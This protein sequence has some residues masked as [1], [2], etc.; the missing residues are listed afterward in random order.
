MRRLALLFVLGCALVLAQPNV[1]L[2]G[3][4][5]SASFVPQGLP[6]GAI[7]QGSLFTIFGSGLGPARGVQV[8]SFPLTPDGFHG[9]SVAVTV[10]GITVNAPVLYTSASQI[11]AM[12]PSS[13]PAG[14]GSVTVTY[15]S[16]TSAPEPVEVIKSSFGIFAVNQAG[17]GLAVATHANYERTSFDHAATAGEPIILWGTGLGPVIGAENVGPLP[18]HMPDVPAQVFVGGRKAPIA[19]EGRSGCCS[20]VDQIIFQVPSGIAGCAVP[21]SVQIG[22][23]ISNF[24]TMA[25]AS[26]GEACSDTSQFLSGLYS[27]L[28]SKGSVATGMIDLIRSTYTQ[29][30]SGGGTSEPVT[31]D[32]F[33]GIF[34]RLT[35]DNFEELI[36]TMP[37]EAV[38]A[39]TVG[40]ES[41]FNGPGSQYVPSVTATYLD[42]GAGLTLQGPG[43]A[44]GIGSQSLGQYSAELGHSSGTLYFNPGVYTVY[45]S[46]GADVGAFQA[47]V[48][49]TSSF[50]WS[51]RASINTINRSEGL[52]LSWSG[53]DPNGWVMIEGHSAMG[54]SSY[55]DIIWGTFTCRTAGASGSFT[56][57]PQV[58]LAVP[59]S[60]LPSVNGDLGALSGL[61]IVSFSADQLFS[62]PGLDVAYLSSSQGVGQ[63]VT[64]K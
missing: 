36:S 3:I 10:D 8:S 9:T 22:D 38:G 4:L 62:A 28:A 5:N 13:T 34:L 51:N 49:V 45:G 42:A 2:G 59:A 63:D 43:R 52:T 7:A 18:G 17:N 46:G 41:W 14:N 47:S 27:E 39:C 31:T 1:N 44:A 56:V 53:A 12:L 26:H 24:L 55:H 32:S 21:V 11:N 57:P 23:K 64:Y 29:A 50:T 15:N 60:N 54:V 16:R 30:P 35:T 19:Y 25:I 33:S 58:L 61:R 20:G 48:P 37:I 40:F 6:S